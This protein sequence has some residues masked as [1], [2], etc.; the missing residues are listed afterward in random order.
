MYRPWGFGAGGSS[1]LWCGFGRFRVCGLGFEVSVL[2]F[3]VWCLGFRFRV[4]GFGRFRVYLRRDAPRRPSRRKRSKRIKAL[5]QARTCARHRDGMVDF[6]NAPMLS[7]DVA[8]CFRCRMV[9]HT[10]ITWRFM[11]LMN[12]LELHL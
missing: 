8:S 11:V 3:G 12:Q 5:R 6:L 10:T 4:L 9:D 1:G 7:D 2:R